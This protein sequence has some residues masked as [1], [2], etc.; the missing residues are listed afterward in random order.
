MKPIFKPVLLFVMCVAVMATVSPSYAQTAIAV[1]DV[2]RILQD[3]KAAKSLQKKR[4]K[5]REEFLSELSQK[6]QEL[7]EKSKV[8]FEKRKELSEEDF[9][10]ERQKYEAELLDVR[11]LTQ[12][13][14]RAFEEASTMS[15]LELR[16]TLTEVVQGI[17]KEEG[18]DLVI[19]SRDV[20]VGENALN[21]TNEAL[22]RL[23]DKVFDIP[24]RV[25]K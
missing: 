7:R 24:F 14:K 10:K 22:K 9:V 12:E 4:N 21:I 20:I 5:A 15:L 16:D 8:L 11:K 2:D 19:S 3:A 6:E 1:V 13:K 23:N 18:Y 25:K 17:A